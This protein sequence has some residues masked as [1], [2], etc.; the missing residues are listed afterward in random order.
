ML[1]VAGKW[2]VD[3]IMREQFARLAGIFSGDQAYLTQD[4]QSAGADVFQI[5]NGGG[6]KV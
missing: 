5:P 2:G 4:T 1:M 6:D 3:I